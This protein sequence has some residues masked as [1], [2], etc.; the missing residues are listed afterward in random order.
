M[1]PGD[2][3]VSLVSLKPEQIM[4]LAETLMNLGYHFG[5]VEALESGTRARD[6][7]HAAVRDIV[8]I[9]SIIGGMK[10]HKPWLVE[11]GKGIGLTTGEIEGMLH[12]FAAN[13]EEARP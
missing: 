6:N 11:W 10:K 7:F 8:A 12:D 4:K 13:A 9:D 3:F 1:T 5:M 2:H